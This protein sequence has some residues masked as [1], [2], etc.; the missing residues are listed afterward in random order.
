MLSQ[1]C[2]YIGMCSQQLGPCGRHTERAH[3]NIIKR[4]YLANTGTGKI[5]FTE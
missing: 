3:K 4:I 5:D 1:W 2:A